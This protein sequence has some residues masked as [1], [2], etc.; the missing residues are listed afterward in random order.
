VDAVTGS[1]RNPWLSI[2]AEDYEGHMAS[3]AVQQL[4]YLNEVFR[5]TLAETRPAA[6]AV[7]GCTTGNGFEHIPAATARIVGIDIHPGYLDTLRER[8]A[9]RLPGLELIR[10]DVR[11]PA[12]AFDSLDLVHCALV[13]EYV[14]PEEAVGKFAGWLRRGGMLSVVLQLPS[15]EHA[16]V[17]ETPFTSVR[18]L[19]PCLRLVPP[20]RLDELAAAAG[21]S[22]VRRRID[23]LP[24]GKRFFVGLYRADGGPVEIARYDP[25]WR[26]RFEVEKRILES[27]FPATPIRVEHI[28]ST[29]VPGLAA[30]PIIDILLGVENIGEVAARIE[31][32]RERDYLYIPE[33]ETVFPERRFFIKPRGGRR[34]VNLHAV[35]HSTD[36]WTRHLLF[37]DVLRGH[38]DVTVEY[39]A[40]KRSLAAR[41]PEDRD[42]YTD[43]KTDFIEA[44][45]RRFRPAP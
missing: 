3:P 10:A 17:T 44:I 5:E 38:P 7:P 35:A 9:R 24:T 2:P 28:G 13:L 39:E 1:D 16:P 41:F 23:T 19:E 32:L 6:L 11:D 33:Y 27:A 22:A 43:G 14:R 34:E 40:L 29:A 21:L 8:F 42:A 20:Q 18:V 31:A 12:L 45:V 36:F 25:R 26:E 37:R 30:K 15:G 4:G